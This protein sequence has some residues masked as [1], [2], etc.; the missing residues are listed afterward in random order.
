MYRFERD[1]EDKT[2]QMLP[3]GQA[4][5]ALGECD[6]RCYNEVVSAGKMIEMVVVVERFVFVFSMRAVLVELVV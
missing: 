1:R 3:L 4:S 6:H 2:Y 5:Y